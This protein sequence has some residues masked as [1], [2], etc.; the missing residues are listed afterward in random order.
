VVHFTGSMYQLLLALILSSLFA[1]NPLCAGQRTE[2][3]QH[4]K[5]A[6]AL[7]VAVSD[8]G[9]SVSMGSGFFLSGDGLLVTNAHVVE[10]G[11]RLLVYIHDRLVATS[12]QVLVTDSDADLAALRVPVDSPEILALAPDN[13]SEGIE[14]MS[15]GY[16][17]ITDILQM[18]FA[19]HST[20]GSGMVS[21][22]A[23][24]RSRTNGQPAGFVQT[25]GILNFGNSGG[26]LID[27]E[28]GV[29]V[30]MV[31]TT[32]PYLERAKDR[33]GTSIG[34]V[35]MKSGI[36]YSIPAPFI[37]QWL[38]SHHL[39]AEIPTTYQA[40]TRALPHGPEPEAD[41][42]FATGHL[43]HSIA[44]VLHNDADLLHLAIVH[45]ET[46]T[47]LKPDAPWIARNLGLAYADDGQ[48]SQALQAYRK[49][50]EFAPHDAALLTDA[51]LAWERTGDQEHA[52]ESYRAALRANGDFGRAHNN[53]GQVLWKTGHQDE[54]ISEFRAAL[55]ADPMMAAASY[56]L[57]LALESQG[58][59]AQA[60]HTWESFLQQTTAPPKS[61][62]WTKKI[63]EGLT[64]LKTAAGPTAPTIVTSTR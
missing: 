17:R 46:A 8:S 35:S 64:R 51:G 52:M 4:A 15:V 47:K 21:G 9:R 34:S 33:A 10:G 11:S 37:R 12:S 61:D 40:T 31:V 38:A 43:L 5:A 22:M 32:V 48:W 23:Q 54:A 55:N 56:N 13:P 59:P 14:V 27:A 7:I 39:D 18:G 42:S 28:T 63:R 30:G 44:M 29:V 25:T 19:L 1:A 26:P 2:M 62:E 50:L 49:G 60:L 3:V 41:R 20:L 58:Q 57:G 53:L 24:G 6:T 16:P 45:Y 36:G